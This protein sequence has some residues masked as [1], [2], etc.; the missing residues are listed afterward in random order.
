MMATTTGKKTFTIEWVLG[1]MVWQI[2]RCDDCESSAAGY[3]TGYCTGYFGFDNIIT[4]M[5]NP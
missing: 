4:A 1:G 2:R 5:Y 3:C